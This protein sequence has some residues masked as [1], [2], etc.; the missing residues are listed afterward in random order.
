MSTNKKNLSSMSARDVVDR[1][2]F[3]ISGHV[4]TQLGR[5]SISSSIVA[6]L[7]L[8]KNAYDADA[9]N[10]WITFVHLQSETPALIIRDDGN[11]MTEKEFRTKWMT[12]GGSEKRE[13]ELSKHKAR[14]MTGEKGLGR[15]GLDR[16]SHK[17]TI[18]SFTTQEKRALELEIDWSKYQQPSVLSKIRHPLYSRPKTFIDPATDKET[19]ISKGTILV[20]QGLRDK[21]VSMVDGK[22]VDYSFLEELKKELALLISPFSGINDFAI[23]LDTGLD[24]A[25]LDGD[26]SSVP[27]LDGAEWQLN[28]EIT[29]TGKIRHHLRAPNLGVEKKFP[30]TAWSDVFSAAKSSTPQ[31]GSLK[32][33]LYFFPRRGIPAL[34]LSRGQIAGFLDANQGIRIYRDHF[35]VRPYGDPAG[36]GDWLRLSYR[37]QQQPHGVSEGKGWHVGSNQ[38]VGAVFISRQRNG[39][40]ID[41]TNRESI[42]EGPAYYDMRTFV[43]HA[44]NF[45]ERHRENY[46]VEQKTKV[47]P[48]SEA[49]EESRRTS[50]AAATAAKQLKRSLEEVLA[51][52]PELE[53][54]REEFEDLLNII[55]Q[56]NDAHERLAETTTRQQ[57][58]KDTLANLASLGI[59]AASFGHETINSIG[60]LKK[61]SGLVQHGFRNAVIA[62]IESY[63]S[64]DE[65]IAILVSEAQKIDS[66][67]HFTL[68]NI[69]RNKRLRKKVKIDKIADNVFDAFAKSLDEKRIQVLRDYVPETVPEILGFEIDWES[70][71]INFLTNSIWAL[72]NTS[73]K[74]RART[75]RC[76]ICSIADDATVE[77]QFSDSGSGIEAGIENDLF[78]PAFST[79][80]NAKGDIVGTGMGLAIVRTFVDSYKGKIDVESRSELGGAKFTIQVPVPDIKN[81]GPRRNH[82]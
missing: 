24:L 14:I 42:V 7:E 43:L 51:D 38:V 66:F 20:L 73:G 39:A 80:R 79:K 29:K 44:V 21:W 56:S 4:V 12:L 6:I 27:I 18:L 30:A 41:Q 19:K 17:T 49:L 78:K 68:R 11:G 58:E 1:L 54:F 74:N 23:H 33:R 2:P 77:M 10:V 64:V 52:D 57:Q 65:S 3:E 36:G 13:T 37:R 82:A 81:R 50:E 15:L 40:L 62:S 63:E 46:E 22:I 16:L 72:E 28:S 25:N 47:M 55:E 59:L 31:C 61:A 26:A 67:A 48:V 34:S 53:G 9:D 60:L 71:M 69:G 76:Q 5:E 32:F 70:I 35:R 45:F 75:I 8:V